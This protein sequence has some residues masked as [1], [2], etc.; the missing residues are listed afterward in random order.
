MRLGDFCAHVVVEDEGLDEYEVTINSSGTQATCWI[1]SEAGKKFS[2]EWRR[3][4]INGLASQGHLTVDGISCCK[5]ALLPTND[6]ASC[7]VMIRGA[8]K[9]DLMFCDLQLS[10]DEA[11]LG[12]SVSNHLGEITLCIVRGTLCWE[13][14][15]VR[16]TGPQLT[17]HTNT[18]HEKSVKKLTTHCVEFGSGQKYNRNPVTWKVTPN[19]D[20]PFKF[21][22]KYRPIGIHGTS[23]K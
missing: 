1:G 4:S 9:R 11:L 12:K 18:Y 15:V 2:V 8:T 3:H 14:R 13:R 23:A 19:Q 17:S 7:T 5:T 16:G 10:D 6:V 21:I 20:P 22:F